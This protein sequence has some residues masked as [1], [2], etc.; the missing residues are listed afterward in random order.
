MM[1]TAGKKRMLTIPDGLSPT[2]AHSVELD[3]GYRFST[4][5]L[6]DAPLMRGLPLN[7]PQESVTVRWP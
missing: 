4:K 2:Y 6:I 1:T 5:G 3:D 7:R